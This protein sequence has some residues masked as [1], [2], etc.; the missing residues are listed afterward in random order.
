MQVEAIKKISEYVAQLRR[1]G[2]G[3]GNHLFNQLK[4]NINTYLNLSTS[5]LTLCFFVYYRNMAFRSGASGCCCV[6]EFSCNLAVWLTF[7]L[8]WVWDVTCEVDL[9][10]ISVLLWEKTSYYVPWVNYLFV[11]Q[12]YGVNFL[13]SVSF[14]TFQ[15]NRCF[16]VQCNGHWS[17]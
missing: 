17:F 8:F 6:I 11:F 16:V 7:E 9:I 1:L 14:R 10:L 5:C 13:I 3:H 12:Y 15:I 4:T 2:K